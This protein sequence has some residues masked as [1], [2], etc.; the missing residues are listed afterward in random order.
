MYTPEFV[1]ALV[2]GAGVFLDVDGDILSALVS[3][4]YWSL[5]SFEAS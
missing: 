4:L 1:V 3:S 2:V 5:D